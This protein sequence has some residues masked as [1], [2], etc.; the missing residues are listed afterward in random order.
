MSLG[1]LWAVE[2]MGSFLLIMIP[3]WVAGFSDRLH[4]EGFSVIYGPK[5]QSPRGSTV[6]K[7]LKDGEK[8]EVPDNWLGHVP[9]EYQ[10]ISTGPKSLATGASLATALITAVVVLVGI[11]LTGGAFNYLFIFPQFFQPAPINFSEQ[12]LLS[13]FA[14]A[15]SAIGVAF[16]G[17]VLIY[18]TRSAIFVPNGVVR[19][20]NGN[21]KSNTMASDCDHTKNYRFEY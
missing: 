3:F 6:L 11:P 7:E 1:Q 19:D 12:F 15:V 20:E 14:P 16:M 21:I 17:C 13:F 9:Y 2:I 10:P 18:W 8:A 4:S 5:K